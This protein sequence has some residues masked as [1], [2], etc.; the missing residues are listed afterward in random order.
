MC[1]FYSFHF[2][3]RASATLHS[4]SDIW[5]ECKSQLQWTFIFTCDAIQRANDASY[6]L[7]S[8]IYAQVKMLRNR[9]DSMASKRIA[10]LQIQSNTHQIYKQTTNV[11]VL[12]LLPS[13]KVV[14]KRI[15]DNRLA[16][17]KMSF[18]MCYRNHHVELCAPNLPI[19][20]WKW[21]LFHKI[22]QTKKESKETNALQS[23]AIFVPLNFYWSIVSDEWNCIVNVKHYTLRNEKM[24]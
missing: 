21:W 23:Y 3:L 15:C 14:T 2:I 4:C 6:T 5:N 22:I 1:W 11:C 24:C 10:P 12:F 20:L 16:S 9:T 13:N 7:H 17:L 8:Y 18:T 19:K